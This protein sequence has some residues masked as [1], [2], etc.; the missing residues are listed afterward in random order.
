M[1]RGVIMQLKAGQSRKVMLNPRCK[2]VTVSISVKYW[3]F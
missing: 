2:N 1:S 3:R